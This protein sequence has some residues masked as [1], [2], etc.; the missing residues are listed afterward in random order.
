MSQTL[1]TSRQIA[2]N[3]LSTLAGQLG[4]P[5]LQ[6]VLTQYALKF[7]DIQE[8][9]EISETL[10]VVQQLQQQVSQLGNQLKDSESKMQSLQNNIF[11]KDMAV[12][13]AKGQAQIDIAVNNA[14]NEAGAEPEIGNTD[15]GDW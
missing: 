2:A 15:I 4:D 1:P 10:N 13:K 3:A 8:A 7:L 9:D 11:Q 6:Q 14:K 5:Q 12:A